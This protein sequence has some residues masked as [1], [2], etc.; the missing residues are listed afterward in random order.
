MMGVVYEAEDPALGRTIALKTIQVPLAA[1]RAERED[2]ER[3][4]LAEARIAA[5]LSHSGIVVVHDVGRDAGHDILYIALEYLHGRT[6]AEL[7]AERRLDWREALRIVGRVAEALHYAH[8]Q[9]VVHRDI[10]PANIM[11]LAS[12]EPKIMDFGIAKLETVQLTSTGQFF[13]T[14][15]F[16]SPE[17][18]LGKAVDARTDL[19]SLGSV[20]YLLLAGGPPFEA[21]SVPGILAR[22]T[23]QHPRPLR[24]A[25]PAV[26]EE[27][28]YVVERAMAK[29]PAARYPDGRTMAED[30]DDILAGR[31]PRHRKGWTAPATGTGTV[32]AALAA[33]LPELALAPDDDRR[34]LRRRRP[35]LSLVLLL[36][37]VAAVYF[38]LHPADRQFW[39]VA[40]ADAR[41]SALVE[42]LRAGR[43]WSFV[44][45]QPS[46]APGPA[47]AP[48][49]PAKAQAIPS[50]TPAVVPASPSPEA[51]AAAGLDS[52]SAASADRSHEMPAS[53]APAAPAAP[54][55][56]ATPE[57]APTSPP[58]APS[59]A[60]GTLAIEFEH[61]LRHGT[62][63]VWVDG[64]PVLDEA[65][66]GRVTRKILTFEARRGMV[67]QQLTL[68]AGKHEVRV[69]VRWDDNVKA[70]RISGTFKPGTTRHLEVKLR[71]NLNLGWK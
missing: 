26:P 3:R 59:G 55:A 18:A 14:P 62:L 43:L 48:T 49:G 66:D 68:A 20:A 10:K 58:G 63:E 69:Q 56:R 22:V 61:H 23:Y 1:T 15:L 35:T 32:S 7:A 51:P 45:E 36:A 13:G 9:G 11:V 33:E 6:L 8:A 39:R 67:Q 5:R 40:V 28:E 54:A 44:I 17:Q 47:L 64:T 46:P 24:E 19:F 34:P 16:M 37:I 4:F 42:Q 53:A 57:D 70:A 25:A 41:Q 65:F 12:G 30:I 2:Y 38:Y 31:E 27:A 71:G 50:A 60:P 52:G 29:D 21:D